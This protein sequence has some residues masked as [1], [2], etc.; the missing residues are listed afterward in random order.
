MGVEWRDFTRGDG[1]LEDSDLVVLEE[2][3]MVVRGYGHAIKFVGRHG[4]L[5]GASASSD[6]SPAKATEGGNLCRGARE[7]RLFH[8]SRLPFSV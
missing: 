6:A 1:R 8:S 4:V 7:F 5:L 2:D 3:L